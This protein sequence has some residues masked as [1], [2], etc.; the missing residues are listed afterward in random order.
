MHD[1]RRWKVA[2]SVL[3]LSAIAQLVVTP[4]HAEPS[5]KPGAEDRYWQ[6]GVGAYFGGLGGKTELDIARFDWLYLC[7]GNISANRETTELLNR[8]LKINPDLKI[9]IRLWPLGGL[10]DCEQNRYQATFLH[11]LYKPGVKQKL[12]ERVCEQIHIVLDHISHPENVV[13]MTFLEELPGHFSGYPFRTNAT[14]DQVSWCMERFR[15]E[16][17]AERGK[18][19]C[20]DDETRL[21]WAKKWVQVM[22]EIHAAIKKESDGRLVFYYLQTNHSTL[23]LVEEGSRLDRPMLIPHRLADVIRPGFCDG[24]FAYPNSEKIWQGK[25][26]RFAE[27]H[28][29]LFFSQ[30][31][32]PSGM[33]LCPWQTCLK[34]AKTRV[35]QNLGYFFYCGGNCATG[36]AWNADKGIP[37]GAEWNTH[38]V[39]AKLHFRRHLALEDVGMDIV[40]GQPP[41]R[42]HLDLPLDAAKPGQFMHPRV[43]VENVREPSF[44][45]DTKEAVA[46]GV[47][48]TIQ[49]PEGFTLP[50]E[51]SAPATLRLGTLEAGERRVADWWVRAPKDLDEKAPGKFVVTAQAKGSTPTRTETSEDLAI[52]FAQPHAIGI[53]GTRWMEAAYRMQQKEARPGIRIEAVREPIRNPAV[54][55]EFSTVT[56][57]GVL[58]PGHRLILHPEQGARLFIDPLVDDDGASRRD[59]DDPTGFRSFDQGY[60]VCRLGARGVVDPTVTLRVAVAGRAE[61][62]GKCLAV[63]RFRTRKSFV[64]RSVLA[65]RFSDKWD[66]WTQE[67]K[68][69]E[70]ALSLMQVFLY[71]FQKKGKVWYGPVKVERTDAEAEGVDV[72]DCLA[73]A[74]PT[75]SRY[76][77]RIYHY[78]DDNPPSIYPRARV[79]LLVPEE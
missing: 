34:L 61:E 25:Y 1:S 26:L 47:T 77:F 39:S 3:A 46:E 53:P 57:K 74:F 62:G 68:V 50:P 73:G 45:L 15:K 69:P 66:T 79:Q 54:G 33:R 67:V 2:F 48:V 78:A 76:A 38:R 52:P 44:F 37:R 4:I 22:N 43:I 35:P 75:L 11:Y 9:M 58:Q 51:N 27:K 19:L 59:P 64:D 72:S 17:E 55:D 14:G 21:W 71:R 8:L 13:G 24:F 29:W 41:L 42:L 5:D 20:W 40:R 63:L 16:I 31:S 6:L 7:F 10:G 65:G 23:D 49:V 56:Y 28:N 36:N 70:G 60:I 18:P 30:A 32:H 12:L